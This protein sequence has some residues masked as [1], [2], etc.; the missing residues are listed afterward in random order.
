MGA[1]T[2]IPWVVLLLF[3]SP[4][5][6]C[7]T[8]T[9]PSR[10]AP[11]ASDRDGTLDAATIVGLLLSLPSPRRR[12]RAPPGKARAVSAAAGPLLPGA[13]PIWRDFDG[14]A[15]LSDGGLSPGDTAVGLPCGGARFRPGRP[16]RGEWCGAV[17]IHGGWRQCKAIG[18]WGQSG[19]DMGLQDGHRD[20]GAA[21]RQRGN[22]A[23]FGPGWAW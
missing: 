9:K 22:R 19:D 6:N 23:R 12:R 11:R 1:K 18:R 15:A 8:S 17:A 2:A 7:N 16:A 14:R 21:A 20:L 10:V 3:Y 4:T 13:C 5:Y